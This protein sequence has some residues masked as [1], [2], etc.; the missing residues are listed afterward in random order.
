[1][2]AHPRHPLSEDHINFVFGPERIYLLRILPIRNI[3]VVYTKSKIVPSRG[4]QYHKIRSEKYVPQIKIIGT[5][6]HQYYCRGRMLKIE[7]LIEES[8]QQN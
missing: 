5:K 7:R 8:A 1:M 6:G 3:L 2:Q 4:G